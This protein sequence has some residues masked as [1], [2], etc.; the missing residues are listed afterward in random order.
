MY[1]NFARQ[2][3]WSFEVLSHTTS[4]LGGTRVWTKQHKTL[5]F[6]QSINPFSNKWLSL[7]S[8]IVCVLFIVLDAC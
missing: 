4:D 8:K 2:K 6:L 7:S 3:G 5:T 1:Q